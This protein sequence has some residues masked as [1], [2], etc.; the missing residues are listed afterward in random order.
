MGA[1][2]DLLV[3]TRY[4]SVNIGERFLAYPLKADHVAPAYIDPLTDIDQ[5]QR[6]WFQQNYLPYLQKK[7]SEWIQM[8]PY[9]K[10]NVSKRLAADKDFSLFL[11]AQKEKETRHFSLDPAEGWGAEDLQMLEAVRILKD[12]LYIK[13]E[14]S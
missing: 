12:M 7:M 14:S 6:P 10:R 13:S 2:G 3:P 5:R 4:A 11:K 1:I 9:L 8:L